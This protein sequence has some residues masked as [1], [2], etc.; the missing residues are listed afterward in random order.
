[1][2]TDIDRE[3]FN[4]RDYTRFAERLGECLSAL[5][6][7]LERPGFGAGPAT[8]GAKLELF[9][10][11]G[12]A[13]PLPHS[14]AIRAAVA[15]PRVTVELDRF[16]LELNASPALLAGRPFAILGGELNVLLDRVANAA[17]DHAGRPALIGILPTLSLADLRPGVS[18]DVPHYRALNSGRRRLRQD[19]FPIRI[20][21]EDPLVLATEDVAL[22]GANGSF[23]VHLRVDPAEFTRTYNAVQLATAPVLAVSGNSPTFLGHRLWEETRIAAFK[24]PVD[25]RQSH[26]PRRQLARTALGTGW[27][28]GGALE[29]F[30]ESVRLHQ[31]LLPVLGDQGLRAGDGQ[32]TEWRAPPLDELRLHQGTVR[33]WNR[34]IYDP[35]S[36]G[37]LRIE[38]RALPAGPTVMD[39][40]A[41]AAFLIGLSVWLAGQD[42]QWTYAL[43]FERA[44]HGFYRAAQHG[45]S[46]RLSW[47][48]GR[49]DQ[50]RTCAAAKLVAE[51]VPAARHG[52]LQAGVAAAEADGLLEVI[53]A[54]AASGQTG[55]VWQRATLAA[56]KRRHAPERALAIML[57]HYLQ[58]A[59]TGMPVHTWPVAS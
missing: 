17:K 29:L 14:Q 24:Q 53:S 31:P 55:A 27:L 57:N 16:N 15:D 1:M 41:N 34:A 5:G 2:R 37:H 23:Q 54:R 39:M 50:M 44:D 48:A 22:E 18:R 9:L 33:R 8:I 10:V 30:T 46:A 47:P 13:R 6:Q 51:L 38:M 52:L 4:E 36:G 12:A 11:D 43:P 19:P 42:Q 58:Y 25:D 40:L 20:A 21:G 45:L 7:L 3:E 32:G 59:E 26:G 49:R 56:A 35:T 28:R